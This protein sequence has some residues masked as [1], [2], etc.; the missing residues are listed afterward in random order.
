MWPPTDQPW[1]PPGFR[2]LFPEMP[3]PP[4]A[5]VSPAARAR[6]AALAWVMHRQDDPLEAR[7]DNPDIP[8]GY[9]YLMQFAGHD[10]VNTAASFWKIGRI[11]RDTRDLSVSRLRLDTLYGGGPGACPF[12]YADD[13]LAGAVARSLLRVGA[14]APPGAGGPAPLRDLP[15]C[16]LLPGG[17]L[18]E[19]LAP[20][21]RNDANS[22]LSQLTVL[23]AAFHNAVVAALAQAKEGDPNARFAAAREATTLIFRRILREDLLGRLLHED[24]LDAYAGRT[25]ADFLDSGAAAPDA[26]PLEFSHGAFRCGHAMVRERYRVNDRAIHGLSGIMREN[27][28]EGAARMPFTVDWTVRWSYFFAMPGQGAP[29]PQPSRLLRPRLSL[30]LLEERFFGE[31]DG[32]RRIGLAYRD[33]LASGLAGLHPVPALWDFLK[34]RRPGLAARSALSDKGPREAA[35]AEWLQAEG[36]SAADARA[37]AADPPLPFY[38]LFEAMHGPDQGRRLGVLG[39]VVVA[40][41]VLGALDRDRLPCEAAG[42]GHGAALARLWSGF[43]DRQGAQ[44]GAAR[45]WLADLAHVADMPGL[46]A[47][48]AEWQPLGAGR[49][50]FE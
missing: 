2:H 8:A 18:T 3:P 44:A 49:V 30:G 22:N 31:V 50:P 46:V 21:Q 36:V 35:I 34:E 13:P 11:A 38:V 9:T 23:F 6:L 10:L 19:A 47:R 41:V 26:M 15:R 5:D 39:S 40:E 24:V 14:M 7:F 37:I 4:P 25:G 28:A 29:A 48:A 20:D 32:T 12:G 45:A 33:L 16:A 43:A 42:G 27:S 1:P 17:R